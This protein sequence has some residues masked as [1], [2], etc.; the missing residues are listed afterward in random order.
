ML[1]FKVLDAVGKG[2]NRHRMVIKMMKMY[3]AIA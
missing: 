3:L 1:H 2:N